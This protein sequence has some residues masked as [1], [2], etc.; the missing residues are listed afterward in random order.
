MSLW[1]CRRVAAVEV[2]AEE[3]P[4]LETV[5]PV[6]MEIRRHRLSSE[7]SGPFG[8]LIE[9]ENTQPRRSPVCQQVDRASH[10][11]LYF[12]PYQEGN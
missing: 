10:G 11:A 4:D 6:S 8:A 9:A 12:R 7:R 5:D 1:A 3:D 2:L